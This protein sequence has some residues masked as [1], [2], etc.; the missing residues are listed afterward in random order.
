MREIIQDEKPMF[1]LIIIDYSM[2]GL[3]GPE[4]AAE[5]IRLCEQACIDRPYIC[6]CT[7][8]QEESYRRRAIEAGM[9]DFFIKPLSFENILTITS[10][11][12]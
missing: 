4:V 8:Y 5:I 3:S 7:S 2:P 10:K 11:V 9:D 1:K 6:C 12:S